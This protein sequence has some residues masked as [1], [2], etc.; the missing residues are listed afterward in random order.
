MARSSPLLAMMKMPLGVGIS[1]SM[2]GLLEVKCFEVSL[3][4]NKIVCLHPTRYHTIY[5]VLLDI[6]PTVR[7]GL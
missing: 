5:R 4:V 2:M 7:D 3:S 6:H 1:R